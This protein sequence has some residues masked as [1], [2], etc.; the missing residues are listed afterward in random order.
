M[1]FMPVFTLVFWA[2]FGT[3]AVMAWQAGLWPVTVICIIFAGVCANSTILTMHEGVHF[4]LSDNKTINE[5][6]GIITGTLTLAPMSLFRVVHSSHHGLIGTDRDLEFWP[7]VDTTS[8]RWQRVLAAVSELIFAPVY[9]FLMLTRA[10]IKGKKTKRMQRKCNRDVTIM[11][12]SLVAVLM[13]VDAYGWWQ[14]FL[15]AYVLPEALAA[16]LQSWRRLTEHVGLYGDTPLTLTRSIMPTNPLEIFYCR[17]MLNENYHAPHHSDAKL[18]WTEL[19][20][21]TEAMYQNEP[22]HRDLFF[23]SYFKAIPKMLK[24]LGDPRIGAQWLNVKQ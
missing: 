24:E 7:Y 17:V 23:T 16:N 20:P 22:E 10:L 1:K 4:L 14:E 3:G 8:K 6:G 19:P 15:I 5:L 11:V 9:Y 2:V 21:A 12:V 18:K 13:V